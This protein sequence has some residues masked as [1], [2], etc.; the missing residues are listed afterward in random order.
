MNPLVSEKVR[1]NIFGKEYEIDPGG[2]TPL[3]A[4]QLASLVDQKMKEI[5]EK[6]RLV[7]TQKIAVLAALNIAFELGQQ[8]KENALGP[9]EER[10]I[11]EMMAALDKALK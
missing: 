5:A 11:H 1:V 8:H 7:D 9:A 6:L 3:E 10:R 4:S 2:L